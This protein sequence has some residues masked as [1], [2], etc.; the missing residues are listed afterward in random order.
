MENLWSTVHITDH[1][2]AP[3]P[4]AVPHRMSAMGSYALSV[5]IGS[6]KS[7]DRTTL[8]VEFGMFQEIWCRWKGRFMNVTTFMASETFD[9]I[10]PPSTGTSLF[11]NILR[12]NIIPFTPVQ[13]NR[14]MHDFIDL[15]FYVQ[16]LAW[17]F[18]NNRDLT[19]F[20]SSNKVFHSVTTQ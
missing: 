7:F 19:L 18:P 3:K 10:S 8:S 13:V 11:T 6:Y 20:N 16:G 14:L 17:T 2:A 5:L 1:N 15:V 9:S 12:M 4:P